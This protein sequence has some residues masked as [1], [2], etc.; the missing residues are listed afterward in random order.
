MGLYCGVDLHS[1]NH[2]VTVIDETDRRLYEKRHPNELAGTLGVLGRFREELVGVAVESTFNWYWLVDGLMDAGFPVRLV[3]TTAVQ[4]YN[5]LKHTDD[6]HDAF[7]L[8]HLMRLGILPTG[9]IYPRGQ[10]GIRDLARQR[11]RLVQH[12]SSHIVSVQNQIWRSSAVRLDAATIRGKRSSVEWPRLADGYVTQSVEATRAVIDTLS[13]QIEALE[14]TL[15]SLLKPT[16]M[17]RL[18]SSVV[19]IGP[20]LAFVMALEIG[21]IGRFPSAGDFASYCRLVDSKRTSNNKT[22]GAGN[23][24]N[25][26]PY[27]AWAF[28]EAAQFALRYLPE[29]KRFYERK[30]RQR[31]M[32]LA[33]KALAHKLAR[34]CYRILREEVPFER[35]RLF[36]P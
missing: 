31:H 28:M 13:G 30:R 26:N 14:R 19:G 29:A 5:G 16:P 11:M 12:R 27:L 9:Y 21:D 32:V 1:N 36:A 10:R 23:R 33:K 7:W 2:V 17:H 4:Q 22:K 8:A 25:G 35:E 3:N 15:L 34:A 20:V 24:K 18:L 6:W